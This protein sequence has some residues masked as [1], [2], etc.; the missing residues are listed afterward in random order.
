MVQVKDCVTVIIFCIYKLFNIHTLCGRLYTIQL[1]TY[2]IIT[3]ITY[4]Y[5]KY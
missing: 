5:I 1:I 3:F 2:Y 4:Y